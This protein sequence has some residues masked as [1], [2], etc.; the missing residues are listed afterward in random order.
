MFSGI[1]GGSKSKINMLVGLIFPK[2]SQLC[3]QKATF[4]LSPLI[5][6]P[7]SVPDPYVPLPSKFPLLVPIRTSHTGLGPPLMASFNHFFKSYVCIYSH[8]QRHWGFSF[9]IWGKWSKVKLLSHVQLFAMPWTVAYQAP[10]SMGFSRQE[11][12]SGLPFP[13]PIYEED[14]CK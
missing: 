9:N 14:L 1:S 10:P 11:Y 6:S 4:S 12:W 8:I 13:S 5:T 3:L 7:L 2:S